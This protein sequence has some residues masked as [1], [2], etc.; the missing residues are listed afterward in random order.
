MKSNGGASMLCVP[1]S[2]TSREGAP[3]RING[4]ST[5]C[6][7]RPVDPAV[8]PFVGL[9][10]ATKHQPW[11]DSGQPGFLGPSYGARDPVK[12]DQELAA[13]MANSFNRFKV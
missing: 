3:A 7:T 1:P 10:E 8:P 9:A 2:S 6:N 4:I 11:S 5:V 13:A 12:G